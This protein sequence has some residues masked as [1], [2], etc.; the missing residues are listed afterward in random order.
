MTTAHPVVPLEP[1]IR[2]VNPRAETLPQAQAE[3]EA[4]QAA[5]TAAEGD[6][7]QVNRVLLPE[8]PGVTGVRRPLQGGTS[9]AI[10]LR[11][12]V[13]RVQD[14]WVVRVQIGPVPQAQGVA[15]VPIGV[16]VPKALIPDRDL[17][18]MVLALAIASAV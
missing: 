14:I 9:W 18:L 6:R 16:L 2:E 5:R 12:P 7:A 15:L 10:G 11:V 17:A 3:V 1:T 4:L 13:T 8:V